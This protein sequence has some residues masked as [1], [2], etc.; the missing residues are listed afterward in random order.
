MNEQLHL[1]R[2]KLKRAPSIAPLIEVLQPTDPAQALATDHRLV[3]SVMPGLFQ[4][5]HEA[6][7]RE[8]VSASPFLWRRDDVKGCYYIL[9]PRPDDESPLFDIETKPFEAALSVG[10]RLEFVLRVNATV[11]RRSGGRHGKTERCDVAMDLLKPLP[12]GARAPQRDAL[13]DQA[14][15]DWLERRSAADGFAI[16]ALVL[17][18]Y[19]AA[20]ISRGSR[21]PGVI[22]I[23]DLR[24]VVTVRDPVPFL[25][26]LRQGFGRAKAFGCGLML[27][28]RVP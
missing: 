3:W 28:R 18:G 5:A 24:G 11:D 25:D 14:A 15:R 19:R 8:G 12:P 17:D 26:R 21:K 20:P 23:F 22:G 27:V 13:A 9:G 7:R 2:I 16:D 4:A 1:S 10:D 6:T